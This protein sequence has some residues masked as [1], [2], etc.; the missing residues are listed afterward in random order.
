MV[1]GSILRTAVTTPN[2]SESLDFT[3]AGILGEKIYVFMYFAELQQL[4]RNETR[5]FN[6]YANNSLW[7][8]QYRPKYLSAD[9]VFTNSP[10]AG[11]TTTYSLKATGNS[12]LPPMINAFESHILVQLSAL[13]TQENDTKAITKIRDFYKLKKHW[14]GDPC[15]P[16]NLTWEGLIC[17][18][19]DSKYHRIVA[20]NLSHAELGGEISPY[21]SELSALVSLNLSNNNLTGQVPQFLKRNHKTRLSP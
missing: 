4:E 14:V 21:I 6:V 3:V 9:T 11:G 2:V 20:L 18:N 12:T 15:E 5:E 8:P 1:P 10:G 19:D 13:P 17:S 7:F 16:Q